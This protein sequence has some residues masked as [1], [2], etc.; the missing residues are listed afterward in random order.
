MFGRED[1][2]V[3]RRELHFEVEGKRKKGRPKRTWKK[4][5]EEGSVNV[6]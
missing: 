3:L 6:G 4:Q 5:V 1:G 2:Q